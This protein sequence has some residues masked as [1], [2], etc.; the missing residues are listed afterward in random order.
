[1]TNRWWGGD[2]GRRIVAL[3]LVLAVAWLLW[4]GIYKPILL[5][6][7]LFSCLLCL[8]LVHRIGFFSAPSGLH[9]LLRLPGYWFW[10]AKEIVKSSIEVARIVLSPRIEINPTVV[11]MDADPQGPIGQ[12]ILANAI[13]LSPGTVAVDLHEGRLTVHCLTAAGADELVNG[14]T[15]RRTAALTSK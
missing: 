4:S 2:A 9:L 13:T 11:K 5:V 3:F 1:V 7:G 8:Y 14:E 15:N 12:A 6:L 10:L